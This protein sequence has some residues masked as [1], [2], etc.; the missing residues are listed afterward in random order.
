[1]SPLTRTFLLSTA[2][3]SK[4]AR[5]TGRER[6]VAPI[7]AR[8]DTL[9]DWGFCQV[10]VRGQVLLQIRQYQEQADSY[11]SAALEGE[12]PGQSHTAVRKRQWSSRGV[13]RGWRGMK[14]LLVLWVNSTCCCWCFLCIC[15]QAAFATPCLSPPFSMSA[16]GLVGGVTG[17]WGDR[18]G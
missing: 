12:E 15:W 7:L 4:P 6:P 14:C 10:A 2:I 8:K 3:H 17:R 5:G 13:W 9:G 11:D 1:M 16:S 18:W